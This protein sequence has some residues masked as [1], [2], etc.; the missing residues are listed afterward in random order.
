MKLFEFLAILFFDI[1]DKYLHQKKIKKFLKKQISEIDTFVDVGS[2]KGTYTDLILNNF[3][4]KKI[5]MFEPQNNIFKFLLKKYRNKKKINIY[6]F[7]ASDKSSYRFFNFNKHDLTSSFSTLD[8]NNSYLKLKAKLFSTTSKGMILKKTK[9]KTVTLFNIFKNKK[10]KK[11]DLIKIDTEG[12]EFQVLQG[13][14]NK[15]HDVKYLLIEFHNDKI[16]LSY[17]PKKLHNFLIKNNFILLEKF[18][19]PFTTWEDRLYLNKKN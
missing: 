16:Y 8:T 19:F 10:V 11:I 18:K 2:H 7:A 15:I 12:H 9:I 3:N 5:L 1:I 14:K 4:P 17:D 6:K 13:L